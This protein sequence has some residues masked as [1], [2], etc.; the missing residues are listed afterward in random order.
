M[1]FLY[2]SLVYYILP[3]RFYVKSYIVIMYINDNLRCWL[4]GRRRKMVAYQNMGLM[5]KG[6]LSNELDNKC[7]RS[8]GPFLDRAVDTFSDIN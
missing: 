6:K 2:R 3:L 1:I 4:S 5:Y 8:V 7:P